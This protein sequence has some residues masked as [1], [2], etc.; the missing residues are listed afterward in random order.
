[1]INWF[2]IKWM[3]YMGSHQDLF[4]EPIEAATLTTSSGRKRQ[5][6]NWSLIDYKVFCMSVS[7]QWIGSWIHSNQQQ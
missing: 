6:V 4:M 2:S 7:L 1:M 5:Y 3:F